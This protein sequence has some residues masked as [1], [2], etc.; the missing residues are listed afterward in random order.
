MRVSHL[1]L[2][3]FRNYC[4]LELD[5]PRGI[6]VLTGANA[7]GKTNLLEA[8]YYLS[9]IHSPR[10][11]SDRELINW[12]ALEDELP[13]ARLVG[14]V[15]RLGSADQ[16]EVSLLQSNRV[17]RGG[18]GAPFR[19]AIRVNGVSKRAIDAS[20]LLNTV[21]FL[22]QDIDLVSGPP[23]LRRHYLDDVIAQID[24]R[25][26]REQHRYR[27][28]LAQRN[29]L[30]KSHHDLRR[31]PEQ[32]T[33]WNQHLIEHGSYMMAKRQEFIYRLNEN[34]G[35][36][37]RQLT[38]E[39]ERLSIT[40]QPSVEAQ[41][42]GRTTHQIGLLLREL[43]PPAPRAATEEEIAAAFAAQLVQVRDK[44][45]DRGVSLVGPHRDDMSIH[46]NDVN[47]GVYGSRGQQRTAA[48]S[49][50]LAEVELLKQQTHDEPVLLLD[51]VLSELD[52]SRQNYLLNTVTQ[53]QQV[54][55]TTTDVSSVNAGFLQQATVWRVNEG[56]I[57]AGL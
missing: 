49:L 21:L 37:H 22:P 36:I 55:V 45:L 44:E 9:R 14:R 40:Y 13:F 29:H 56:R 43:A 4:R 19:S 33:F 50:K 54:L 16:I 51:D 1:S 23:S 47:V 48:L 39:G 30:L 57:E 42:N 15:E 38:G 8:I 11:T 20:G 24:Y 52:V 26:R 31:D 18:N 2:T 35:L 53:A 28:V 17:G 32:L 5:L 10:T 27:R 46:V 41:A 7:Q 3:N 12:L 6:T 34:G 25:Y